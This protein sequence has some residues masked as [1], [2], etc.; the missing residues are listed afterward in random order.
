MRMNNKQ[1]QWFDKASFEEQK[2]LLRRCE[3][4]VSQ[5]FHRGEDNKPLWVP[6][7]GGVRLGGS[8]KTVE[9][10]YQ[11]AQEM[12]E[13][14]RKE[15][16]P[17]IDVNALGITFA[18]QE[19]AEKYAEEY[20]FSVDKII[21]IASQVDY[22]CDDFIDFI[23]DDLYD[24][25]DMFEGGKL[26]EAEVEDLLDSGADG[27]VPCALMSHGLCGWLVKVVQPRCI[28]IT[29]DGYIRSH[30]VRYTKWIYA[31]SYDEAIKKAVA[32]S[33]KR[34]ANDEREGY[35]Q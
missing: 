2:A 20:R 9:E 16:L 26:F 32:W 15:V 33:D 29:D 5:M 8:F 23:N 14:W 7:A 28:N 22:Q 31:E 1:K 19:A 35:E 17:D 34:F 27:E 12:L 10:A 21:H 24:N 4:H 13:A 30:S 11:A 18:N 6:M 3:P 25:I